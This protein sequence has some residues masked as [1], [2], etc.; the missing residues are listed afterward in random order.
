MRSSST[1]IVTFL[2][3]ASARPSMS[4]PAWIRVLA[5]AKEAAM[6][7]APGT[8]RRLGK[9]I[10]FCAGVGRR[11]QPPTA[12]GEMRAVRAVVLHRHVPYAFHLKKHPGGSTKRRDSGITL[13]SVAL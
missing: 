3:A 5:G 1:V 10:T 6:R 2:R 9:R 13:A 12:E 8:R 4:E 7:A 11:A